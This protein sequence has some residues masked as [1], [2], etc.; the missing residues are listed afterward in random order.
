[1][2]QVFFGIETGDQLYLL[3]L[4][5]FVHA[6]AVKQTIINKTIPEEYQISISF[7]CINE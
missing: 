2:K 3:N 1:M 7:L 6:I 5:D 4:K